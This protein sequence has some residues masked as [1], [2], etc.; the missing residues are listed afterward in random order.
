MGINHFSSQIGYTLSICK[1]GGVI[2]RLIL[3]QTFQGL[4]FLI[5]V[6]KA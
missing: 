3:N 1:F 4:T 6:G 5:L 2:V